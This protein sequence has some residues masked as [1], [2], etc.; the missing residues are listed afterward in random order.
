MADEEFVILCP[1]GQGADAGLRAA[2]GHITCL[3][4]A[5]KALVGGQNFFL[6]GIEYL[7]TYARLVG[8]RDRRRKLLQRLRQRRVLGLLLGQDLDLCQRLL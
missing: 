8:G 2:G 3:H 5:R 1:V 6:D 4:E 7:R